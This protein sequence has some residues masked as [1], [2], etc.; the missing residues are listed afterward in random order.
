MHLLVFMGA[1]GATELIWRLW[2]GRGPADYKLLGGLLDVGTPWIAA[3]GIWA[4][5]AEFGKSRTA[6]G[7]Y[8]NSTMT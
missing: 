6:G 4:V 2:I 3:L 8:S 5:L 1:I 7:A